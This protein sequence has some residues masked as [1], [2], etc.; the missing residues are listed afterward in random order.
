MIFII[1]LFLPRFYIRYAISIRKQELQDTRNIWIM[2]WLEDDRTIR[3][4]F[5][6][7]QQ[8]CCEGRSFRTSTRLPEASRRHRR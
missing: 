6:C 3:S 5:S 4:L 7:L 1:V 8:G 2:S